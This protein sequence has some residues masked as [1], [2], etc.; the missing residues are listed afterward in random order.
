MVSNLKLNVN[1]YINF[2]MFLFIYY[3]MENMQFYIYVMGGEKLIFNWDLNLRFLVYCVSVL[4]MELLIFD[5]LFD[6][7]IFVI[8]IFVS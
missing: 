6:R 5:I 7:Y 8:C 3:V 2:C 1:K 4:F